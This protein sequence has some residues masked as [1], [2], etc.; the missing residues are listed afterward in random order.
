M[1]IC[2]GMQMLGD[3]IRDPL[4]VESDQVEV[5]GLG[6]LDVDREFVGDKLTTRTDASVVADSG[7]LAGASGVR[8]SGYEIH[9]GV[10]VCGGGALGALGGLESIQSNRAVWRTDWA[11]VWGTVVEIVWG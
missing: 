1:G 9:V 4:G 3:M 6:I 2:G 5:Q 8:V 10:S 11:I 7:L